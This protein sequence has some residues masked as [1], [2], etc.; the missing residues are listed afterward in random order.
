MVNYNNAIE[1]TKSYQTVIKDKQSSRLSHTY[2]LISEDPIYIKEFAKK[3]AKI[4]IGAE[5]DGADNLQINKDIHPDV[6]LFG[7]NQKIM[8]SDVA[9]IASDVFVRPYQADKKVYILL[10]MHETNDEVQNK[11]LK[12]IEEPPSS[13]F[14]ILA[15][16]SEKKLLQTVLSRSKKLELDL[17]STETISSMLE[18]VGVNKQERDVYAACSCGIFSRAYK[19]ATDKDFLWLYDNIFKALEF[20]NSS[21]DV[22]DFVSI[23]G[24]KNINKEEFADLFMLIVR[25]L[26]MVKTSN[27]DLINNKHKTEELVKIANSFALEALYKIIEYCLQFKEDLVYNTNV[28]MALDEFLL[29]CVEVKVKCKKL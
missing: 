5:S 17:L 18:E 29:K 7:E 27:Y 26:C 23:F 28:T 15:S 4:M 24:N 16:K 22:L 12:T 9:Q 11:L 10:N 3:L 21:R 25:D 6:L 20:M 19:M 1:K 14:F 13:V 2:L 8:T